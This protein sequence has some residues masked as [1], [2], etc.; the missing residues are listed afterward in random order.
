MY[1][2]LHLDVCSHTDMHLVGAHTRPR[3]IGPAVH[4]VPAQPAVAPQCTLCQHSRPC[5]CSTMPHGVCDPAMPRSV[6][7]PVMP[8]GACDP[9]MPAMCVTRRCPVVC[10]ISI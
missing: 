2:A 3:P 4:T 10:E 6:C 7:D 8:R 9:A 1:F 5:P